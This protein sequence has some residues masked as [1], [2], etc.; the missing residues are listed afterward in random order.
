MYGFSEKS[1]IVQVRR[2]RIVVG[3]L[4]FC[5]YISFIDRTVSVL[6]RVQIWTAAFDKF[7]SALS[8]S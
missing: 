4:Q 1:S 2:Y 8:N 6:T 5:D 3:A 7:A